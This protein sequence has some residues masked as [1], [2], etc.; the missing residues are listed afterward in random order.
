MTKTKQV[1]P[2]KRKGWVVAAGAQAARPEA[3]VYFNPTIGAEIAYDHEAR[4]WVGNCS[5]S[6]NNWVVHRATPE[7]TAIRVEQV[8]ADFMLK[9]LKVM[10]ST[11]VACL[12]RRC[13]ELEQAREKQVETDKAEVA[14]LQ[15]RCK[16]LEQTANRYLQ[17]T[18]ESSMEV[19]RLRDA[20]NTSFKE[21]GCLQVNLEMARAELG[22]LQKKA[23]AAPAQPHQHAPG[24]V[25]VLCGKPRNESAAPQIAQR[26]V[27]ELRV[28]PENKA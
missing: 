3:C 20:L 9:A 8:V 4:D 6:K 7:A 17:F 14:R 12:Q 23:P 2:M 10:G 16:D 26:L 27:L 25:C 11:E 5:I 24:S 1:R 22:A 28:V 15:Q 13:R 21:R 18:E 19:A